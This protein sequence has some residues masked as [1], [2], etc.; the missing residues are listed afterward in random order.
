V[1]PRSNKLPETLVWVCIWEMGEW[2]SREVRYGKYNVLEL[3]IP[4]PSVAKTCAMCY[5]SWKRLCN[6]GKERSWSF[7]W[8]E[9]P[10]E[11]DICWQPSPSVREWVPYSLATIFIISIHVPVLLEGKLSM[12]T[13]SLITSGSWL[14]STLKEQ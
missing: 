9:Y 11:A 10:T 13:Y 3:T 4:S 12:Y 5:G 8:E 7:V 14:V 6:M 1:A 2:A